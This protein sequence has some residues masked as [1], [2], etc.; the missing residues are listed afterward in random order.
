M[1]LSLLVLVS[2]TPP[3]GQFFHRPPCDRGPVAPT[4]GKNAYCFHSEANIL[5]APDLEEKE[6]GGGKHRRHL[7]G[8]KLG[9]AGFKVTASDRGEGRVVQSSE[10]VK[11]S[12][13]PRH[14]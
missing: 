2:W 13:R 1:K 12:A 4:D 14:R 9:V 10:A 6:E 5:K 3:L 8:R 7:T 11:C